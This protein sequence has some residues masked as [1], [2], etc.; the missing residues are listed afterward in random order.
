VTLFIEVDPKVARERRAQRGGPAE[1]YDADEQ[2][3]AIARRYREVVAARAKSERIV[4]ID[5]SR[6]ISEVTAA[7]LSESDSAWASNPNSRKAPLIS[8]V[9]RLT[10]R[11]TPRPFVR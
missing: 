1:L 5:G 11:M 2:Q 10:S 8:G 3:E 4:R 7:C 6:S 9:T